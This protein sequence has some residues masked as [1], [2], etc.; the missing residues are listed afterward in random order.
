[1]GEAKVNNSVGIEARNL[2]VERGGREILKGMSFCVNPG[3]IYALLGGNGAGKSTTL[4]SC[5][6]FLTPSAGQLLIGGLSPS[7]HP[8]AVRKNIAYV[9]ESAA[10]YGHLSAYE[11]LMYF[12]RL[13]QRPSTTAALDDA[14]TRVGLDKQARGQK[15]SQYS[16]GMRQKVALALALLRDTHI[17]L[18]DEPTSGLD[19]VATDDFHRQV[20]LLADAGKAIL[21]V[22]HDRLGA[23]EI[24]DRIG[25]LH[26]GE[27]LGELSG[28]AG[29]P[30]DAAAIQTLFS[31]S[32]HALGTV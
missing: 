27:L 18:L 25:L 19:P 17:L 29:A 7:I 16:K 4:L 30:I 28:V 1:M 14:L 22:T 9:P 5:L 24:A 8:D 23:C 3:Q 21:M 2:R 31:Q 20:R 11:N 12:L 15:L 6:G 26:E 13:A 10:L 32:I